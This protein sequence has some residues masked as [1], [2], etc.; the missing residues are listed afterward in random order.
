MR[1][2]SQTEGFRFPGPVRDESGFTLIELLV[3]MLVSLI[4]IGGGVW[5]ISMAFRS[6]SE[7]TQRTSASNQAEVRLQVLT[8]DLRQATPCPASLSIG[9]GTTL[10]GTTSAGIV[11]ASSTTGL[12]LQMCDPAPGLPP[13]S[14]TSQVPQSALVTWTCSKSTAACVRQTQNITGTSLTGTAQTTNTLTGVTSLSLTGVT[15]AAGQ[16][17]PA[18]TTLATLGTSNASA[19]D[20]LLVPGGTNSSISW[21]GVTAQIASLKNPD[22]T[23]NLAQATA[24]VPVIVQTGIALRNSEA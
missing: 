24:S 12:T 14:A 20:Y 23:S 13:S 21:V 3:G 18:T 6:T 9:T 7:T 22:S 17:A 15:V 11:V 5:G 16:S 2:P 4:V 19:K 8:R 1:R 10:D